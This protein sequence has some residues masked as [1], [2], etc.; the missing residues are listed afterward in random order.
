MAGAKPISLRRNN[1]KPDDNRR[2]EGVSSP[3]AWKPFPDP[4]G[5]L[6]GLGIGLL[7]GYPGPGVLI[8]LGCGFLGSAFMNPAGR[9]AADATAPAPARGPRWTFAL[10]GIC[11]IAIG[12]GIVW[13]PV[14]FWP[15]IIA[16]LLILFG[17]WFLVRGFARQS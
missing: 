2:R 8:G 9:P 15:Y 11:M 17:I 1:S 6:I 10:L 4:G 3:A 7:A 12:I 13:A 14:N 16:V 5:V